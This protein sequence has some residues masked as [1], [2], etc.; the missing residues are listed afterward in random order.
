M[1]GPG[2][3]ALG[4]ASPTVWQFL[5]ATGSGG[6]QNANCPWAPSLTTPLTAL[7]R[8]PH[9]LPLPFSAESLATCTTPFCYA[10][11]TNTLGSGTVVTL[12]LN[13]FYCQCSSGWLGGRTSTYNGIRLLASW[14]SGGAAL[15]CIL[16]TQA[17]G[18]AGCSDSLSLP[19]WKCRSA[20]C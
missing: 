3:S 20:V 11:M 2:W 12:V 9:A 19:L 14:W 7:T 18:V 1:T 13:S 16:E 15:Q 17:Q 5:V 4:A 10:T 8:A 6:S